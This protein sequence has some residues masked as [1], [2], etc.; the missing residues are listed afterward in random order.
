MYNPMV[1]Y[2]RQQLLAQQQMIQNQLNQM[3]PQQPSFSPYPQPAQPQFVVRQVGNCEEAKSFVVDPNV[4]YLFPDT[5][6][7]KIYLKKLN[8]D[9]GKSDFY[10]YSVEEQAKETDPMKEIKDRLSD[11]ERRMG[12]LYESISGIAEHPER[13]KRDAKSTRGNATAD[14]AEN[15][16]KGSTEI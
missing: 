14:T 3:P 15:A 5:G 12:G 1:D 10:V 9:T 13:T 7:G 11:I 8:M 2:K 6:T 4:M 16:A